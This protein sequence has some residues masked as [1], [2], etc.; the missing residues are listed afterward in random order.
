M[1]FRK[2]ITDTIQLVVTPHVD[3]HVGPR[4]D[5]DAHVDVRPELTEIRSLQSDQRLH[6]HHHH[7][8]DEHQ[9]QDASHQVRDRRE[10]CNTHER[11]TVREGEV[12]L[13]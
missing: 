11:D 5:D 7:V 12:E 9:I 4:A 10:H 13:R 6:F 3:A 2:E 8:H 1:G